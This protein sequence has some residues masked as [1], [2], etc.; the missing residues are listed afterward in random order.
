MYKVIGSFASRAQRVI[1]A[2]EEL[3][4]PYEHVDARPASPE[5]K[6]VNP[7]G[8]VPA[9]IVGGEVLSDSG[10]IL[11][12]LC[13]NHDGLGFKAGTTQR[14]VQDAH[15]LRAIDEI[16][17]PLWFSGRARM[18]L[19]EDFM[20]DRAALNVVMKRGFAL[21]LEAMQGPYL[22]GETFTVADIYTA[23]A[24]AWAR[25]RKIEMPDEIVAYYRRAYAREA[26]Q[27]MR[28]RFMK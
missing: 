1:W 7:S 11:N 5:I 21:I 17:G 14:A 18:M 16:D 6:A 10:A 9:L 25:S 3:G 26:A 23:H 15:M 19:G 24:I 12:Y 2:L 4:L 27:R 28:E 13:D 22:Q 20:D 8:K